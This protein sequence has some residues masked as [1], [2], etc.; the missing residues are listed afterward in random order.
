MTDDEWAEIEPLVDKPSSSRGRPRAVCRRAAID[1][2]MWCKINH[3]PLR[4]LPVPAELGMTWQAVYKIWEQQSERC[5]ERVLGI[6]AC[7]QS[8]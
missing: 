8:S 3:Q 4:A 6:V 5:R 7:R 2:Y 1:A